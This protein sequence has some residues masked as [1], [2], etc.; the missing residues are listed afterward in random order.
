MGQT[1]V[2]L[3]QNTVR[4]KEKEQENQQLETQSLL[5]A[6]GNAAAVTFM[7]ERL[8]LPEQI[9]KQM[10]QAFE[11]DLRGLEI[12]R[13]PALAEL[14]AKAVASG[15]R[16]IIANGQ[17]DFS[18]RSG[19]EL[20]GHEISHVISQAKGEGEGH[21]GLYYNEAL[22][23]KADRE[24]SR[25]ADMAVPMD[26]RDTTAGS[27]FETLRFSEEGLVQAKFWSWRNFWRGV[28]SLTG[29]TIPRRLN[30]IFDSIAGNKAAGKNAQNSTETLSQENHAP[31]EM[32]VEQQ[33]PAGMEEAVNNPA[34]AEH[35]G[36]EAEI[37]EDVSKIPMVWEVATREEATELEGETEKPIAPVMEVNAKQA[38][39]GSSLA[40][41]L[42]DMGH[43][44]IVLHYTKFNRILAKYQRYLCAFG[45]YPREAMAADVVLANDIWVPGSMR[46]DI[47]HDSDVGRSYQVDNKKINKVL[48]LAENYDRE[49]YSLI[50]RNCTTFAIDAAAEAGINTEGFLSKGWELG[51]LTNLVVALADV[52]TIFRSGL[53][54]KRAQRKT[55]VKDISYAGMTQGRTM[56]TEEEMERYRNRQQFGYTELKGDSPGS[57]GETLR[58]MTSGKQTAWG[59]DNKFF[60]ADKGLKLHEQMKR[61]VEKY[62]RGEEPYETLKA[63]YIKML[64]LL[65]DYKDLM[66]EDAEYALTKLEPLYEMTENWIDVAEKYDSQLGLWGYELLGGV[67]VLRKKYALI[68]TAK[69]WKQS[70]G[71][72]MSFILKEIK[73][74]QGFKSNL[75]GIWGDYISRKTFGKSIREETIY[76]DA[77]ED[78][79]KKGEK[80][81]GEEARYLRLRGKMQVTAKDYAN[82]ESTIFRKSHFTDEELRKIML[83]TDENSANKMTVEKAYELSV[84]EMVFAGAGKVYDTVMDIYKSQHDNVSLEAFIYDTSIQA[85]AKVKTQ[86][87]VQGILSEKIAEHAYKAIRD[88]KRGGMLKRIIRA[89]AEKEGLMDLDTGTVNDKEQL[90]QIIMKKIFRT[91]YYNIYLSKL[92]MEQITALGLD[93]L[94]DIT[95][96]MAGEQTQALFKDENE[97]RAKEKVEERRAYIIALIEGMI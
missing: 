72:D 41:T 23:T 56:V 40:G 17:E 86:K 43:C 59:D 96:F 24:G 61:Y 15:N 18:S 66:M 42:K 95:N 79:K 12:Y 65:F 21:Q 62:Y 11:V 3:K 89:V 70:M 7:E 92:N 33:I 29:L 54:E 97:A 52:S 93:S 10:E 22:E 53:M 69:D 47:A 8:E 44:F 30:H 76:F 73:F 39:A 55:Q 87:E 84:L 82:A 88:E 45:F 74:R 90:V 26:M 48:K 83:R 80:L 35:G 67:N 14:G 50:H 60:K 4:A 38:K 71:S 13:S 5:S 6:V 31:D 78:K 64:S 9:R 34:V 20:L 46:N 57:A 27:T 1:S 25:A 51:G 19:Q 49:G 32:S 91:Y 68:L 81:T 58:K 36:E 16:I 37:S 94:E 28:V 63:G 77:L 2:Q 85:E 75:K